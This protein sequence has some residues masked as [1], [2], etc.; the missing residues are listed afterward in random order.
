MLQHR[1]NQ[2]HREILV[3][4]RQ[5]AGVQVSAILD[6]LVTAEVPE[7]VAEFLTKIWHDV[8]LLTLLRDGVDSSH[9]KT[10]YK[11]AVELVDGVS[12]GKNHD[13]RLEVLKRIPDLLETIRNALNSISFD[14][15]RTDTLLARIQREHVLAL[16]NSANDSELKPEE[17]IAEEI[18]EEVKPGKD[19]LSLQLDV[20][21]QGECLAFYDDQ[22]QLFCLTWAD[23]LLALV[24]INGQVQERIAYETA[25][26]SLAALSLEQ[27]EVS[28]QEAKMATAMSMMLYTLG[29]HT[30]T[31]NK[32]AQA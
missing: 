2:Q 29:K 30:R 16:R 1:Q 17:E 22:E 21:E 12:P 20:L 18:L 14:P 6:E 11:T 4:Q 7:V 13:Q 19:A 5:Q 25:S 32:S 27:L 31:A 9:W 8:M 15:K 23:G 24:D 28:A 10:I 26:T 3:A